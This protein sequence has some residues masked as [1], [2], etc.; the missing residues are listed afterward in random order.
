MAQ[1]REGPLDSPPLSGKQPT[2]PLGI[3]VRKLAAATRR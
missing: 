3:H 1:A 2:R